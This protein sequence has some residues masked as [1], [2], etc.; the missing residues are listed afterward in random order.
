MTTKITLPGGETLTTATKSPLVLVMQFPG[1]RP[2]IEM[3]SASREALVKRLRARR[4]KCLGVSAPRPAGFIA[5]LTT[6]KIE[7]V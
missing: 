7:E 2:F 3:R 4:A 5:T 6:G 1:K